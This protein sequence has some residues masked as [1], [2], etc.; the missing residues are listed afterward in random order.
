MPT[1]KSKKKRKKQYRTQ[2][3]EGPLH[4]S[5]DDIGFSTFQITCDICGQYFPLSLSVEYVGVDYCRECLYKDT[6]SKKYS[7]IP[8]EGVRKGG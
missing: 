1:T 2:E 8:K 6:T 3:W 7:K 4:L 5:K